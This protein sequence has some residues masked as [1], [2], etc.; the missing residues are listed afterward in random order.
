MYNNNKTNSRLLGTRFDTP[1]LLVL[2]YCDI[3]HYNKF[4]NVTKMKQNKHN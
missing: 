3:R 2:H 1:S 4:A